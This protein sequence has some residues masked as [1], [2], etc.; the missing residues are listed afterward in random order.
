MDTGYLAAFITGLLGGFGHCIGMCGPI[1]ASYTLSD[2]SSSAS[3]RRLFTHIFYNTGR[4]TTYMFIGALMGLTGSFVNT[5][6]EISGIQNMVAIIAGLIMIVMGLSIS[7]VI[8]NMSW[9]E[10]HN[11][12]LMRAGKELLHEKSIWR[13]YPLGAIF[14]FL[15]CGLSYTAFMAAAGTGSLLSGML[16]M[17]CFGLGTFP[18]LILFGMAASYISIKLRGLMYRTAGI[19]VVVMGV[20]FLLKGVKYAGL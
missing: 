16:L 9:L 12:L 15:P 13:Y 20:Y 6:G 8:G 1:V 10:S 19:V 5:A 14:G 17:L 4:I 11:S 2:I 18:A 3:I 7:G